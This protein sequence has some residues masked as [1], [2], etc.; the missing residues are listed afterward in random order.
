L[1]KNAEPWGWQAGT[2]KCLGKASL[3]GSGKKDRGFEIWFCIFFKKKYQTELNQ[4]A[5][6]SKFALLTATYLLGQGGGAEGFFRPKISP[7]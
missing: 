3:S 4:K 5:A 2:Q 7:N 6:T 1:G